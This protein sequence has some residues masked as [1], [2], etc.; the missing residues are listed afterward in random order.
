M[1]TYIIVYTYTYSL[2]YSLTISRI[3]FQRYTYVLCPIYLYSIVFKIILKILPILLCAR[4]ILRST[5]RCSCTDR[6]ISARNRNAIYR[7]SRCRTPRKCRDEPILLM[8]R[9]GRAQV[10]HF[11]DLSNIGP[12]VSCFYGCSIIEV[13][14][15]ISNYAQ[16][17]IF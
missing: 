16:V 17:N 1:G 4:A 3:K 2:L 10:T 11:S 14:S 13:Y 7:N 6:R 8:H 15:I 5:N 12:L 9:K